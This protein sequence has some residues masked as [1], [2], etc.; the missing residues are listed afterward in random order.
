MYGIPPNSAVDFIYNSHSHV[1]LFFYRR[2]WSVCVA[3][4]AQNGTYIILR[5]KKINENS[6]FADHCYR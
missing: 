4:A 3:L 1:I 2:A 5:Q 6:K